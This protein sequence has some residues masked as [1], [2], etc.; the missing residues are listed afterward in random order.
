MKT[1]RANTRNDLP[2]IADSLG[3]SSGEVKDMLAVSAVF[4]FKVNDYVLDNLIDRDNL[5]N[6]PMYQL[7]FPQRDMLSDED[8]THIRGLVSAGGS[9]AELKLAA[10][11]IQASLNPHPAGQQELNKPM[12]DGEELPGMQHKYNETVLFFPAQGQTCHAYCT[13]CFRWAQFIGDSELKFS[14]KE[15]DQLR[16]YVEENPQIDSVLITGGDPMIMKTKFLRQYIEPLMN[17]PHLNSIRV[18]TKAIAYWPYRFTE[19]EDAD[20]LL[21]L[22]G[23][24]RKAGKNFAVMAHSS[25]PV[26]FSTEV[27]QLAVKR[28]I[29]AGAVVRC[30]APLIKRV[31]D[32]PDIW[33]ALWRKQVA[34]GAVPYYMF[35]E[36]DTGPKNYF[37]VPLARAYDIFSRAYNQVSGLGRTVRGPSMSC[38]PGK[39]CVDGVT[40]VHGEKVFVMKFIQG[41][42]PYWANKVFFAKYNPKATWLDDLEPALDEDRFFFEQGMDEF[43]E[44]Y[45]HEH[46]DTHEVKESF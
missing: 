36:R 17:I 30:Q 34:L 25:H 9:D 24:V 13:Y 38:T 35:V 7:T 11:E 16:R 42:N 18:G 45:Q 21:R 32:H 23:E 46:E 22:I 15:A 2:R 31:N 6:D 29:D 44:N 33:A 8:F 14:N 5:P 19:G 3:L 39:V 12:L 43:V 26:E 4:P 20:D 41:R 10:R 28:L 37:E 40:E 1:Y 27:S